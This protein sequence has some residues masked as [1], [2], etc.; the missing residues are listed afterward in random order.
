VATRGCSL[1]VL[2]VQW[3]VRD[4]GSY[5]WIL[6]DC[7]PR[8]WPTSLVVLGQ[9]RTIVRIGELHLVLQIVVVTKSFP[10]VDYRWWPVVGGT[11]RHLWQQGSI[12]VIIKGCRIKRRPEENVNGLGGLGMRFEGIKSVGGFNLLL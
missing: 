4:H 11:S 6:E 1:V 9:I 7:P 3:N 5:G 12:N 8:C 2:E 10:H